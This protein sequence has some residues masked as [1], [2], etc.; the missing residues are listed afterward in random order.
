MIYAQTL[1]RHKQEIENMIRVAE[2]QLETTE[3]ATM[4]QKLNTL[5]SQM[6]SSLHIV[7]DTSAVANEVDVVN[8]KVLETQLG[9]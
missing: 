8:V 3:D 9:W 6:R 5:I 1:N 2:K 7:N 4:Y